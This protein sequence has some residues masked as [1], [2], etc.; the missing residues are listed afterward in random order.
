VS[1][2]I[3]QE[4]IIKSIPASPNVMNVLLITNISA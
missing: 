3:S 4:I 2:N 1:S